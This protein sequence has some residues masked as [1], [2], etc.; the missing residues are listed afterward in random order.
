MHSTPP[1]P[2]SKPVTLTVEL[3]NTRTDRGN[4]RRNRTETYVL[5]QAPRYD[6]FS[7]CCYRALL[8]G[9]FD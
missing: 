2:A 3:S 9:V 8:L 6:P 7:F 5:G 1:L 4:R